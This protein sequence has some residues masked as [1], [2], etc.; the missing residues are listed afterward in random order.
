MF[1]S[2]TN[3]TSGR[4]LRIP[5]RVMAETFD[6][7]SVFAPQKIPKILRLLE[8]QMSEVGSHNYIGRAFQLP[9]FSE[10]YPP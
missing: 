2:I 9:A 6:D 4:Y 5:S 7:L 1:S 10:R 8:R 3:E